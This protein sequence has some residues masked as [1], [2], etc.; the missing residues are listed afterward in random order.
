MINVH[1]YFQIHP[2]YFEVRPSER[3]LCARCHPHEWDQWL[4]GRDPRQ[5]FYLFP[6]HKDSEKWSS[7]K[8]GLDSHCM[9]KLLIYSV[10]TSELQKLREM[11]SCYP[12]VTQ[13]K[14]NLKTCYVTQWLV[15]CCTWFL[16]TIF[17]F[18]RS[19]GFRHLY[20]LTLPFLFTCILL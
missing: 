8:Q 17:L 18:Y 6:S 2:L 7:V 19:I 10:K 14:A 1:I 11:S 15:L 20:L 3:G 13:T 5:L 9:L 12:Q 16:P 4:Y